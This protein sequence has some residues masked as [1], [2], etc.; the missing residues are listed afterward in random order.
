M[1]PV[2]E[3]PESHVNGMTATA[4]PGSAIKAKSRPRKGVSMSHYVLNIVSCMI[5][6]L[7]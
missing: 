3:T 7:N 5:T 6:K 2:T 1:N 4:P